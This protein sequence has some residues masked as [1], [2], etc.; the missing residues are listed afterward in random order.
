M[1]GIE[2][3]LTG[4]VT[5]D[6]CAK[7]SARGKPYVTLN[8]KI[9]EGDEAQFCNVLSFDVELIEAAKAGKIGRGVQIYAEGRLTVACG[10]VM[11]AAVA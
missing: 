9:G 7:I 1:T 11:M 2:G 10:Q 6:A 8:L 3:A 5:R 4:I